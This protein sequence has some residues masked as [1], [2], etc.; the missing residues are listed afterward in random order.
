[1]RAAFSERAVIEHEDVVGVRN[2]RQ[3]VCDGDGGAAFLKPLER[4]E[5]FL[6]GAGVQGA[7]RLVEQQDRRVLDQCAGDGD[8]LLLAARKL[9][10][11]LANHRAKAIGQAS[12][13]RHQRSI[14]RG[15]FDHRVIRALGPVGDVI[16]KALIEQH[17]V[18]RNDADAGAQ[19][20]LGHQR[21]ILASHQHAAALRIIE[22]EQQ[23]PDGA[24]ARARGANDRSGGPCRHLETEAIEDG[25]PRLVTEDDIVEDHRG[26]AHD[27]CG[28]AG[29]ILHLDIGIDQTE[30][31]GHV[32]QPLADRAID[33]AQYVQ[34]A[35]QLDQER[36]DQHQIADCHGPCAPAPDGIGHCRAHQRIGDDRLRHVEQAD[37]VFGFYRSLGIGAGGLRIAGFLAGLGIEVFHGLEIEQRIHRAVQ[38]LAVEIVHLAPQLGAPF[39]DGSGDP[40]IQHHRHRSGND[41]FDPELEVEDHADRDQLDD[42][43]CD[44]EQQEIEHL[45]DALGAALDDLGDLAGAPRQVEAQAE[46]VEPVEHVFRQIGRGDLPDPLKGDIAQIVE[47]DRGK[48]PQRIGGD[49]SESDLQAFIDRGLARPRARPRARHRIDRALIGEGQREGHRLGGQHQHHRHHDAPSQRG[50]ILGPEIG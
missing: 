20:V 39:G 21:D 13:Q 46:A 7:G 1:M 33:P 35:E 45:V 9:Q 28:R 40:D 44:V 3:P 38:R 12:D 8:A 5:D 26:R 47:S 23:P 24:L 49:Q 17:R 31:L 14:A 42:R 34:R 18:L 4:A 6:L 48:A 30:H 27:Q 50:I 11:A 19:A 2:G 37:R 15:L 36:I 10:S 41:K 25:A 22:A 16:G 29:H 43:R 32:D